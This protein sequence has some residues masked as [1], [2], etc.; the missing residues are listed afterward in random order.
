MASQITKINL[1]LTPAANRMIHYTSD[2]A[3][4]MVTT[5][6]LG[7]SLLA[8]SNAATAQQ[9]IDVEPGVDVQAYSARLAEIA[10]LSVTDS[11]FIVGN[12]SSWV[13]ESGSTART[14][15]G[16][17]TGDSPTFTSLTLSGNLVVQGTQQILQGTTYLNYADYQILNA[18]YT[19]SS[20]LA[21]GIVS[22]YQGSATSQAVAGSG[23]TAGSNGVSNP[24]IEV[25]STTGFAAGNF[26]QVTG[27]TGGLNDG[28]YEV[29]GVLAGPARLDL[30]G[31]GLNARVESFTLN[32]VSTASA[33]GTVTKCSVSVTR[34]G[35]D[36]APEIAY[37]SATGLTYTNIA[38]VGGGLNESVSSITNDT[39][40]VAQSYISATL[41]A[42]KTVTLVTAP[43]DGTR[44]KIKNKLSSSNNL[45]VA[46]GG[47]DTMDG[48]SSSLTLAPGSGVE[49][50]YVAAVTDWEVWA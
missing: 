41:S 12:G 26:V 5:A 23:F 15:M 30:R 36:G 6:A 21:V 50:V 45:L 39:T 11:N 34:A 44:V 27:T 32:D 31:V 43:A 47:S 1:G 14:S 19:S 29:Q 49:L 7:L 17:G 48:S 2:S 13:A 9:A 18:G 16:L 38:L 42:Q 3:A 37:G 25:G 40:M 20:A 33:S 22:I 28:I 10:A 24:T 46:R 35:T 8:A 4:S